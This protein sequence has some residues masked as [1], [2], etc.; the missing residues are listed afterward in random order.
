M[1]SSERFDILIVGAGAAG[2]VL[3]RRLSDRGGRTVCVLDAGPDLRGA[4]PAMLHDGWNLPSGDAWPD[5]GYAAAPWR[6]G[7]APKLRRG[8]LLGGTSWLTR[9][10]VR[11]AASDFDG[12]AAAGNP[13]WAFADV[14]PAFRR[15]EHD[16]EFG[17]DPGHGSD[18]PLSVTRYPDIPIT[19]VHAAALAALVDAGFPSLDDMNAPD[20]IGVGRMP[21]SSRGGR[22]ITTLDGW[23]PARWSSPNLTIRPDAPVD[24]VELGGDRA[25]GVRL[26]DGTAIHADTVVLC[27]GVYG[28]PAILLRSGIGPERHLNDLGIR[29]AMSLPGV[30]A[31]LADHPAV[32]HDVGWHGSGADGPILHSIAMYRSTLAPPGDPGPDM[33]FW[34]TD[35]D[36]PDAGFDLGP[37]LLRPRSRGSVR[38]RSQDP[39]EAPVIQLPALDDPVDVARLVEGYLRGVELANHPAMLA[40][41]VDSPPARPATGD[42]VRELVL[43]THG[44]IPHTV[45]TCAMGP[46]PAEGAVVGATGRI[47]GVGGLAVVDASIMPSPPSGFPHV[48]TIML[49]EQLA[50]TL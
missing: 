25:I 44:S 24:R 50:P 21:M 47:H 29:V 19:A 15:L 32:D 7:R 8:R 34:V 31:N 26:A 28:S 23:L 49:A 45:G 35:P 10:A 37:I 12:W 1:P 41:G 43:A 11:G 38:L 46:D 9:F 16:L 22:R 30:G 2:C 36:S 14:L 4:P 17:A 48:I 3:A 20:P 42:A 33:L 39:G 27:A 6:D 5:W 18:G 13:G 40:A